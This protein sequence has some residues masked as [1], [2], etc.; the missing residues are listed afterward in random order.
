[1]NR[2]L[3]AFV[4]A[5]LIGFGVGLAAPAASAAVPHDTTV[6]VFVTASPPKSCDINANLNMTATVYISACRK[7]GIRQVFP[8]QFLD[9]AIIK[10]KNDRTAAGKTAWKLLN[11]KRWRK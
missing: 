7:A 1:M 8:G 10:I 4:S 6:A 11:D 5:L 3:T 9:A 2:K